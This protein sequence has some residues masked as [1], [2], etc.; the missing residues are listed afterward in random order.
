[1]RRRRGKLSLDELLEELQE[2]LQLLGGR[3]ETRAE[4]IRLRIRSLTL[5]TELLGPVN[6]C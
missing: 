6:P 4:Q 2:E 5:Q 1:M 3:N